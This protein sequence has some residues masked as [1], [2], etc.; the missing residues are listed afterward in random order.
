MINSTLQNRLKQIQS[1]GKSD[2]IK[3]S[4]PIPAFIVEAYTLYEA[5]ALDREAL[6]GVGLDWGVVED[7][8]H[9]VLACLAAYAKWR[10]A[11]TRPNPAK[12]KFQGLMHKAR[13]LRD[14]IS[15][16]L[17][18]ACAAGRLNPPPAMKQ[19]LRGKTKDKLF[20]ELAKWVA[21]ARSMSQELK[22]IRFDAGIIAEA[23]DCAAELGTAAAL[24]LIDTELEAAHGLS[25]RAVTYLFQSVDSIRAA[26]KHAFRND[27]DKRKVY[28][29]EYRR[30]H[31]NRDKGR[32]PKKDKTGVAQP[33]MPAA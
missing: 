29:S 19:L 21:L 3:L 15:A 27:R 30:M 28:E 12:E 6:T 25:D 33:V 13:K 22:S 14:E 7:L 11:D 4:V 26:G 31:Q 1:I 10:A 24:D 16:A 23:D 32:E 18:Y 20:D 9:R 2:L 8:P 5:C 17:S